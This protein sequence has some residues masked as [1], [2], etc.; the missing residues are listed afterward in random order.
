M[1]NRILLLLSNGGKLKCVGLVYV[2]HFFAHPK[3][4]KIPLR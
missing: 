4:K 1:C 2:A 3:I